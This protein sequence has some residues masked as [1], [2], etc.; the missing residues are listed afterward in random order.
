MALGSFDNPI[1]GAAGALVINQIKSQ[2]FDQL[3]QT[4][5]AILKDG[6]AFFFNITAS[7]S[8]TA[9][10]M[11]VVGTSDGLFVY[12]GA[13]GPGNLVVAIVSAAGTDPYG[14]AYSGPGISMSAPGPGGSKNNIQVRPDLKA[15]LVYT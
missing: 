9:N 13:A 5:W 8:I 6:D 1:T 2:N 7:G 12:D 15:V 3:A 10:K 4:G 11:V 14:N